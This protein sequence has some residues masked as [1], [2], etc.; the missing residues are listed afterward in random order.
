MQCYLAV[1]CQVY[2]VLNRC[3]RRALNLNTDS[4]V[5]LLTPRW[6][7]VLEVLNGRAAQ[8]VL[9]WWHLNPRVDRT[10]EDAAQVNAR[11]VSQRKD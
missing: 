9:N 6:R 11:H 10:K 5:V 8:P 7:Q 1:L 4:L 2:A 3:P